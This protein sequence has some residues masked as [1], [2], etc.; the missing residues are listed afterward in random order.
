MSTKEQIET[1]HLGLHDALGTRKKATDKDLFDQKH[2]QVWTDCNTELKT[3]A[4]ELEGKTW[5]TA[6]EDLELRE[7]HRMFPKPPPP[8]VIETKLA[9]IERRL[10][11]MEES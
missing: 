9:D 8:S 4:L 3:R 2:R 6:T 10:K 5:L 11:L 1:K 7:L